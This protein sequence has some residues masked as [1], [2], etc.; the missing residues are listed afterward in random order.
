MR[1]PAV[2]LVLLALVWAS[3]SYGQSGAA[4]P[5]SGAG[6]A[7]QAS[8]LI[9]KRMGPADQV[10]VA[11]TRSGFEENSSSMWKANYRRDSLFTEG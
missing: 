9:L 4:I 8:C 5:Q 3:R 11:C 10:P 2:A 6:H 1:L 7:A